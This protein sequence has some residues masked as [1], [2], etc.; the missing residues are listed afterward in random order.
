MPHRSTKPAVDSPRDVEYRKQP[1]LWQAQCCDSMAKMQGIMQESD[2]IV[3]LRVHTA[4]NQ[5]PKGMAAQGQNGNRL[6]IYRQQC[7][8][9]NHRKAHKHHPD[10][11]SKE[12]DSLQTGP[13][14]PAE[15]LGA[16]NKLSS[17]DDMS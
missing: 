4:A 17:A 6:D 11:I 15:S 14:F 3:Y 9:S 10:Y 13:W 7:R 12:R 1:R 16:H 5:A 8:L 2:C